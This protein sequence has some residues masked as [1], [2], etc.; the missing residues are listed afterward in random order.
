M[1]ECLYDMY[2]YQMNNKTGVKKYM[3][4]RAPS[5]PF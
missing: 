2:V 3:F 1:Y 4:D 5:R